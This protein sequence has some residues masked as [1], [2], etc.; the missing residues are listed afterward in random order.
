MQKHE[1][2]FGVVVLA[3]GASRRMGQP[4]LLLP[5]GKT[6]VI[7]HLLQQ[8]S[9]LGASQIAVVSAAGAK[10]LENELD[11]LDF[12]AANRIVNPAPEQ[13]MFSSI[14]CAA[15]WPGWNS[16]LTHWIV[17]LGDQPHLQDG[18][19]RMLLNFSAG[20]PNKIC[21]P[22]RAGRRKHP[23]L[24]PKGL[25]RALKTSTVGDLKLFLT[26]HATDLAGYASD[27]TSLDFDMDTPEDYERLKHLAVD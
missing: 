11:R 1:N 14:Q 16:E 2:K 17:T 15:N 13:G 20:C 12:P 4:K 3:A 6:T 19:L 25:F 21:Q 7:G 5:W 22:L 23:V 24:L 27:D 26:A 10:P 8:W 9:R 18:T